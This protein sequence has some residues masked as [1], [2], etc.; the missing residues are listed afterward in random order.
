MSYAAPTE[1]HIDFCEVRK[2]RLKIKTLFLVIFGVKMV[3]ASE[4]KFKITLF[5]LNPNI[6]G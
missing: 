1:V 5:L 3:T 4:K 6:I 2:S